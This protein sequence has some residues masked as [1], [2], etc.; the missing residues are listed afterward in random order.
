[1]NLRVVVSTEADPAAGPA[2]EVLLGYVLIDSRGV[3]VSSGA[4][5][6]TDGRHAFSDAVAP[7]N[8]TLRV[9]G[10][11]PLGRRGLVQR[12]FFAA[13]GQ[14]DGVTVSDLILA[15]GAVPPGCS[16][17]T[18]R[19][20]CRP[21]RAS[22]RT[23]SCM[24][25][26]SRRNLPPTLSVTVDGHR[27]DVARHRFCRRRPQ[28]S[29]TRSAGPKRAAILSLDDLPPGRYVVVAR[30]RDAERELTRVTRAFTWERRSTD[31]ARF[32]QTSPV[33]QTPV[34]RAMQQPRPPTAA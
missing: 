9:G 28:F 8:Y 17:G 3:V 22:A 10:I 5:R 15:R 4:H 16:A 13:L 26:S 21:S 24:P 27:R 6:V 20:P 14:R 12:T 33:P 29:V 7:G 2:S 1:M 30:V 18:F 23:S 19:R 32:W 25:A 34:E 11:D 31:V